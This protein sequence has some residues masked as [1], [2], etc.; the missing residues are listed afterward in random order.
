M[1]LQHWID[2]HRSLFAAIF[3]IY[4]LCLSLVVWAMIGGWFSL[5]EGLSHSDAIQWGKIENAERTDEV[6]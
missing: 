5:G 1:N 3:P 2:Q 6:A 4:F